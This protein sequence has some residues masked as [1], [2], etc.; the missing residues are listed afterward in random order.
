MSRRRFFVDSIRQGEAQL[1][2]DGAEH[3][4][5]V[6]RAQVGQRFEITDDRAAWLAEISGFGR[7]LVR[8]RLLEPLP[9]ASPGVPVVLLASLFKFDRFEWM[10]E[11]VTELGV[12]EIWPVNAARTERGLAEGARKRLDRWRKL[13]RSAA[14]QSRRLHLPRIFEPEELGEALRQ[15]PVLGLVLD[16]IERARRLLHALPPV[17]PA[18]DPVRLLV[19]P[20]GGWTPHERSAITAAGWTAVSL[21][22]G[23]LRAETA[24]MAAV[25]LVRHAVSVTG[26]H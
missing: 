16:E 11:K 10:I 6:L 17:L 4:R 14:E 26:L 12:A 22:P 5:R 1:A 21:G 19:G 15:R 18:G 24:A 9:E 8:F 3:L 7:W 23:I 25:A 20:E 13:A 2:G